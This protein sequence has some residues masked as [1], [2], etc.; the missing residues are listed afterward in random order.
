MFVQESAS[1]FRGVSV[2]LALLSGACL[3]PHLP[4]LVFALADCC[5]ASVRQLPSISVLPSCFPAN[6]HLS[7]GFVSCS[8]RV[9]SHRARVV[10]FWRVCVDC[11]CLHPMPSPTARWSTAAGAVV[12]RRPR[13]W[14]A[15]HSA[16]SVPQVPGPGA[17]GARS[18]GAGHPG[19]RPQVP[20]VHQTHVRQRGVA[21]GGGNR[22][23]QP[24]VCSVS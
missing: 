13:R 18:Q 1:A 16:P 8:C 22:R 14:S 21:P 4:V 5:D 24:G 9:V 11:S 10:L 20:H 15:V 6:Q 7:C 3:S 23:R 17:A 19:H 12:H 2:K